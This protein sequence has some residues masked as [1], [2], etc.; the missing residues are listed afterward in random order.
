MRLKMVGVGLVAVGLALHAAVVPGVFPTQVTLKWD[1]YPTNQIS[2]D[3]VFKIY[4]HTNIAVPFTNWPVVKTVAGTNL[5]T[6]FPMQPAARYFVLTASNF[7]GESSFS[8]V[9]S[10][11][12]PPRSDVPLGIEP[13][14]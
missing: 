10:T 9:A 2:P 6:T 3:L 13:G 7:W 8:N 12:A 11:P 14:P 5:S 1:Q 4:S